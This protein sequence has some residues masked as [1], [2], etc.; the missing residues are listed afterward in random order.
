MGA[1]GSAPWHNDAAADWFGDVFVG[2]DIDARIGDALEHDDDYDRVR[3]ACYLLAV[4]GHSMVWPGDLERLDG[5][6]ERGVELL[7]EMIEPES[8]FRELW[9]D[10]PE[11]IEAVRAEIAELEARLDGEGDE[12]VSPIS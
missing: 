10:D 3:A 1:W 5:H 8:E 11:V 6:L 7:T 4:L 2:I 9:E 12:G